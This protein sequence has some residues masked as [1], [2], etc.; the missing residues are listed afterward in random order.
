MHVSGKKSPAIC[1]GPSRMRRRRQSRL[2]KFIEGNQSCAGLCERSSVLASV[3]LAGNT[4]EPVSGLAD[5]TKELVLVRLHKRHPELLN[6]AFIS[7]ILTPSLSQLRQRNS[8]APSIR[9]GS[10]YVRRK[11]NRPG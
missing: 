11:A 4:V 2:V 8:E 7:R 5:S 6:G 3:A 9:W 1:D 10:P